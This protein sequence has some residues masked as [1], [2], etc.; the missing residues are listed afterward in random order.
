M[1]ELVIEVDG[2]PPF[3][4]HAG[5]HLA[6][7]PHGGAPSHGGPLWYSIASAWDG[8]SPPRLA[9]AIGPGTGAEV[10]AGT[11]PGA[12][13]P[14]TGPFGSFALPAAAGALL[15]GVG[16]GVAPLRA[17]VAE[18]INLGGD[19]PLLLVVGARTERDL[20]WHP[21]FS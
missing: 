19:E 5:Q 9:L 10:L 3:R 1:S 4:W 15:I 21:E 18:V 2:E 20:L 17:M 14:V 6:I 8:Q 7:H 16:T 11:G 13:L 12:I